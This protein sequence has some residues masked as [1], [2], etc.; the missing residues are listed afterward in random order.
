MLPVVGGKSTEMSRGNRE[1]AEGKVVPISAFFHA[2]LHASF[3]KL[4]Q[5]VSPGGSAESRH[6]RALVP[7]IAFAP[8]SSC[9]PECLSVS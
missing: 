9:W 2:L 4:H 6:V 1:R 5:A 8:C 3:A 7:L